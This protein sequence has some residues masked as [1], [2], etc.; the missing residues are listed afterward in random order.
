MRWKPAILA[1]DIDGAL[2]YIE[3]QGLAIPRTDSPYHSDANSA[4][5]R[6]PPTW[7][8]LFLIC[9]RVTA[10]ANAESALRLAYHHL[11]AAPPHLQP[12]L[13]IFAAGW[14]AQH[15]L[16]VLLRRAITTFLD[17][18]GGSR[19][20]HFNVLLQV[21][22]HASPTKSTGH[23]TVPI[24]EAALERNI[25]LTRLTYDT[26]LDSELATPVLGM[27]IADH[28]H[29]HGVTPLVKNLECWVKLFAKRGWQTRAGKCL[30]LIRSRRI[31]HGYQTVSFGTDV[32][33]AKV[34]QV[35]TIPQNWYMS[36][37]ST[38]ESLRSAQWRSV[39]R[40]AALENQTS[41][42]TLLRTFER[43]IFFEP[44]LISD[45]PLHL[46]AIDGLLHRRQY[47]DAIRLWD[48]I[49]GSKFARTRWAVT[50][51]VQAL[52]L[53]GCAH[54]AF[55][56]IQQCGSSQHSPAGSPPS[57]NLLDI[58]MVNVY[59]ASLHRAGRHD[60]VFE[61]WDQMESIFGVYPDQYTAS[62]LFKAARFASKCDQ[63]L[64]QA[65]S[66]L[67][68]SSIFHKKGTAVSTKPTP[69]EA[70]QRLEGLLAPVKDKDRVVTGVWKGERAGVVALRIATQIFLGNWP[71]LQSVES[72]AHAIR[73]SASYQALSPMSDFM[74]SVMGRSST[75][76]APPPP[77]PGASMPFRQVMPTDVLFRTYIDLL[78][79]EEQIPQVPLALA[80]MQRLGVMP[81]RNTLATALVYWAEVSMDAPLIERW[82]GGTSEYSKLVRWMR[83]WIGDGGMPRA[84]D[85][86]IHVRRLKYFREAHYRGPAMDCRT[87]R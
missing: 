74:H 52:T 37:F 40:V 81:S 30:D 15:G 21:L 55:A 16:L 39:L 59:M 1:P 67:G 60:V 68:L 11:H 58:Q 19:N 38:S 47:P 41:S 24:L 69:N 36:A 80:W 9:Y 77:L 34:E 31:E 65:L 71:E 35:I 43:A 49:S 76:D 2:Q 22:S 70:I 73:P 61:L 29:A 3:E 75:P 7:L 64:G 12:F 57:T 86:G 53:G 26:M 4:E 13:L 18:P 85:I 5:T 51:G 84:S 72:P 66:D 78:A 28:M 23:L 14:L 42:E 50:V 8:V 32:R 33:I 63:S 46:I 27:L 62:I 44:R 48:R 25:P 79:A 54:E 82:K 6:Q 83:D 20:F 17:H 10:P 45:V 56:L 87:G